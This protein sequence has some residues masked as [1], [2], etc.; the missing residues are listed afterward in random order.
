MAD[1]PKQIKQIS[2]KMPSKDGTSSDQLPVE[3]VPES[4]H[5]K[6]EP[7]WFTIKKDK[8][9]SVFGNMTTIRAGTKVGKYEAWYASLKSQGVEF[10]PLV[11]D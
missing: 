5:E 11:E 10:E 8:N 7:T 6:V 4:L 2:L 1:S 9:V 3:A